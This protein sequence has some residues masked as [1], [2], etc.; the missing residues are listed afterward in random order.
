MERDTSVLSRILL[1]NLGIDFRF[2]NYL[3]M[4]HLLCEVHG[5]VPNIDDYLSCI[6]DAV[7]PHIH[8]LIKD[9]YAHFTIDETAFSRMPEKF[10][11]TALFDITLGIG[12]SPNRR[13]SYIP[14]G[15][16]IVNGRRFVRFSINVKDRTPLETMNTLS[17]VLSHEMLHAYQDMSTIEKSGRR[18]GDTF[19]TDRYRANKL[20]LT[21]TNDFIRKLGFI[22]YNTE[23]MEI[24][25]FIGSM[26]AELEAD[27]DYI[28]GSKRAEQA[29]KGTEAYRRLKN[30]WELLGGL[31][32]IRQAHDRKTVLQAYNDIFGTE[33]RSRDRML[34]GLRRRL[35]RF[36]NQV[37]ERASK[38]AYD[39]FAGK[40]ISFIR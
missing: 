7:S 11:D 37:M 6:Q 25:A 31:Q 32:S 13:G 33:E 18:M 20:A 34:N 19:S 12:G 26:K 3:G 15:S 40:G 14:S 21:S 36:S 28:D 5:Y 23:P 30:S 22:V 8:E 9:G 39:V 1:E 10:F 29:I 24:N 35:E 16:G 38:I 4:R 17:I 2:G 27:K